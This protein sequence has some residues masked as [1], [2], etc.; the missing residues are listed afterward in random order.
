MGSGSLIALMI[1]VVAFSRD[2]NSHFENFTEKP[3]ITSTKVNLM[4]VEFHNW[5]QLIQFSIGYYLLHLCFWIFDVEL[6][7]IFPWAVV[8]KQLGWVAFVEILIF[9]LHII[10][11][12]FICSQKKALKWM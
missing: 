6:I 5:S 4:S 7:F 8:V 3:L 1:A 2:S 9:P 12:L 11:G 10:Y